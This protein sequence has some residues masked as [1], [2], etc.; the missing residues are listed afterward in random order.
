MAPATKIDLHHR[1]TSQLSDFTE[2]TEML[3]PGNR[4]QQYAAACIFFE[5][6]WARHIVPSLAH[7]EKHYNVSRRILQRARAKLS[8]LGLIEYIS[9][10][11]SRYGGQYGWRLSTRL[12]QTLHQIALKCADFRERKM[13]SKENDLML[14]EFSDAKRWI[15]SEHKR[16]VK[17]KQDGGE[18]H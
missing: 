4:N 7:L 14:L 16:H 5:L 2:L 12:E 13:S 15:S 1:R 3:F 6:K 8:R 11:N 9:Y 18:A 10:L 17:Q